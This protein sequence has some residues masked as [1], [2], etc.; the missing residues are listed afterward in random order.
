MAEPFAQQALRALYDAVSGNDGVTIE[1]LRALLDD[2]RARPMAEADVQAFREGKRPW[3]KLRDEV[4][5]VEQF[6][7]AAGYAGA[8][9]RFPLDDQPPDA[10]LIVRDDVPVGIEVT[11]ARARAGIEVAKSFGQGKV[12]PGFIALPEGAKQKEFDA[13]RSR[14]RVLHSRKGIEALTDRAITERLEGKDDPKFAGHILV[15][16]APLI[17][18]PNRSD[19]HLRLTHGPKAHGL[20]FA[21]VFILGGSRLVQLK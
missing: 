4:L 8:K 20:A 18:S 16:T 15:I 1:E 6:L 13:A 11:G 3:K 19:E 5:P 21:K 10:W 17:S 9:V 14:G 12:V 7:V 2:F